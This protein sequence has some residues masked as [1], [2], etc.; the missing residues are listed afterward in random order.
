[1][2]ARRSDKVAAVVLALA[3]GALLLSAA[4]ARAA[5]P[6]SPWGARYWPDVALVTHEGKTVRFYEDLVKDKHVVVSF[7]FTSCSKQCGPITANLVRVKRAMGDRVGRDVHF[8]SITM[9]PERDTP[10]V[11]ARYAEAFKTGPGWTF[12]TGS[13][14]DVAL[15]RRKFGD[16]Q[17]VDDHS[18]HVN[19]GNDAIGQWMATSAL[20]NPR[21]LATVIGSWLDPAWA[22]RQPATPVKSYA[23]APPILKPS[24]GSAIYARSCASC[25][26]PKGASVGPDLAGVLER[27]DRAWVTR[28][29]REPDRMIAER[30]PLA[31]ELVAAHRGVVMPNMGLSDADVAAVVEH[32]AERGRTVAAAGGSAP[33]RPAD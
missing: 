33:G 14:E 1:V 24:K 17:P 26:Q 6:D 22:T 5:P 2:T 21:Y 12:L 20:D 15:L 30:E 4:V 23:E 7:I 31:V 27:R 18:A 10:E 16:L 13:E 11:L 25:H 28:W 19:V 3:A 8:Y 9:D 32:L 29:I